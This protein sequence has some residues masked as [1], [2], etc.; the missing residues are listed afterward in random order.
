MARCNP[1][2]WENPGGPNPAGG[3]LAGSHRVDDSKRWH[4]GADGPHR[5]RWVCSHENLPPGLELTLERPRI[6]ISRLEDGHRTG[7]PF[8]LCDYHAQLLGARVGGQVVPCPRC[9]AAGPDHKCWLKLVMI[10]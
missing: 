3:L 9:V 8:H 4:C 6:A 5:Y 2:G 7:E 10:S 1:Y